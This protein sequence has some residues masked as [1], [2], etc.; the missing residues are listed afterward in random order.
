MRLESPSHSTTP[1]AHLTTLPSSQQPPLTQKSPTHTPPRSFYYC[2][3][4][5]MAMRTQPT[6]SLGLLDILNKAMALSPSSFHKGYRSSYETPLSSSSSSS[7]TIPSQK[8]YHST[9]ELIADTETESDE[10]EEEGTDSE[11]KEATSEDQ[12]EAVPTKDIVEDEPSGL[13]YKAARRRAL[14]LAE[15][16]MP[17]TYEENTP[18]PGPQGARKT[19]RMK[20][21][22]LYSASA[23]E[24]DEKKPELNDSPAHLEYA[25]LQGNKSFPIIISSKLSEK[26]KLSLLQVLEKRKGVIAWKMSDIKGIRFDIEIKD[27]KEAENLVADHLSRLE[28]PILGVFTEEEITDEFPDEHLM[29]LKSELNDDEPWYANYVNYIV[30]KIVPPKWTPERRRRSGN[31]SS[32]SEMPQKNIQWQIDYVSK[33]VEAQALPTN[34]ARVVIKFLRGLFSR[35]RVPKALITDGNL[36]ELSGEEAWEAIENFAQ[37]QKEWD[38]PPNIISEQEVANLKAQA[39]RLFGNKDVWVEMHRGIAWDKVENSDPQSTPQVLPSFEEYTPPVTCPKEVE[40][41]LGTPIEVEP[42][43]ET[44][45]EKVG[46][47]FNHNTPFS[48]RK[49]LV[50][51][52]PVASPLLNSPSIEDAKPRLIRWVLLLQGFNIKIKDKK[53]A[54]NLAADHLSR[55]KNL[56]VGELAKKEIVDEFLNEHL[57]ILKTK[58]NDYEH[59]MQIMSIILLEMWLCPNNIMRRCIGG[60]EFLE[61][62]AHC[63]SSPTRDIIVP[64]LLEERSG[65]ISSRS[66]MPQNNILTKD[67]NR[68]IKRILERS[69]GYNPKG[70]SEKL[71]DALWAFRTTYKT[72]TGC[73]P[74]QLVYGKAC[75]LPVEIKH[76]AYWALKQCNIYLT[77][78]AKNRFMELNELMELK[79]GAYEITRIYKERTKKWHESRLHGDKYFK[80]GDKV[81]LFNSRLR[82]HLGKLKSKWYG[83]YVVKNVYP[84]RAVEITNKNGSSFK[85]NG[86]RLKK[87]YDRSIDTKDDE[88]IK[89]DGNEERA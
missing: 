46:L 51:M 83:P 38:N 66:E 64:R 48:S 26:E 69:V 49:V 82:L 80:V 6:L 3:T 79:D 35:F 24:I 81:L 86:Q 63:H 70:W 44:K 76:K 68:A 18:Y 1:S 41:T 85:V 54:E 16:I 59:G 78:A 72:P 39:K 67:T 31:I 23:N 22:H 73:T 60:N 40:K 50:L 57:M 15:C 42:L 55:L 56:G 17:S 52:G 61:I 75:H 20:N 27:K 8:R 87:Y 89:F 74:F 5:R 43:N 77:A 13:G 53:G 11:S 21:E 58:L 47:N 2:D 30:G 36:G 10:S 12:Q 9:F 88:V 19:E 65:N 7:S 4:A 25:Y 29:I 32:R 37:G 33:W 34:D 71:N 84:Y 62:L 14:E 28:N 45:L